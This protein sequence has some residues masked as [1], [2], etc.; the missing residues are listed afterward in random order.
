MSAATPTAAAT[1]RR[2]KLV[3]GGFGIA[4]DLLDILE[5]DEALEVEV[6]VHDKELFDAVPVQDS[7]AVVES[8]PLRYGDELLA[9]PLTPK[10]A[11]QDLFRS[12][13]LCS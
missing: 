11:C 9:R 7:L 5:R 8:C 1:R 12:A 13:R 10:P 2:P 3:L 6:L 4:A